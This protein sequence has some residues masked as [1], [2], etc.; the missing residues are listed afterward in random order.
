VDGSPAV[1]DIRV[2]AVLPDFKLY[3]FK[4]DAVTA[5]S[6]NSKVSLINFWATWCEA[7]MVEMPSIIK[8]YNSYKDRGFNVLAVDLDTNPDT[9]LPRTIQKYGMPFTVYTD[10][11]SQLADLFQIQA[12]PLSIV[13]DRNRKILMIQNEGLDWNGP[14]FKAEL[15]KWLAG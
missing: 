7:C 2:G 10:H 9:V 3:A 13:I 5:S 8:L 1:A 11:E 4:G 12:I 15:E 14:E 6:L